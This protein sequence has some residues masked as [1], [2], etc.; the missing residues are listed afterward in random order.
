MPLRLS[1]F[2]SA[3]A[4]T[5]GVEVGTYTHRAN[6][7]HVY[8]RDYAMFDGYIRRITSGGDICFDYDGN[9]DELMEEAKPEI[10]EMVQQLKER[11]TRD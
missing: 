10:A 5:L 9:W 4:D 2:K 11:P 6:S 1:C 8:E 7:F 3:I